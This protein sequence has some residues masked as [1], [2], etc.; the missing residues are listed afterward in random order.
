MKNISFYYSHFFLNWKLNTFFFVCKSFNEVHEITFIH[1]Y[2][3]GISKRE[4]E[5]IEQTREDFFTKYNVSFCKIVTKLL[6]VHELMLKVHEFKNKQ[7]KI[8]YSNTLLIEEPISANIVMLSI[9]IV[10]DLRI[11]YTCSAIFISFP[12]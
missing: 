3:A 7:P 1:F 12:N 2:S 6:K 4:K 5:L 9:L 10:L 8:N 11:C